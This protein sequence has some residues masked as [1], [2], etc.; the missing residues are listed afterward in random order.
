MSLTF[1]AKILQK[2]I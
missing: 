2:C 1:A